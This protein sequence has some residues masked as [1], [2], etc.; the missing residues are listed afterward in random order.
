MVDFAVRIIK[1][2]NCL[3]KT[4]AGRHVANQL[5][6]SG[7]SPASNY[8]EAR[9][10]ES[11]ADF[12]HKLGIVAKELNET[13]VWLKII[14]KSGLVRSLLMTSILEETIQLSKIVT[15]SVM[16]AKKRMKQHSI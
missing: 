13:G 5:L 10:A 1:L 11:S 4:P 16:T 15:S 12:L 6:R 7:T 14:S 3:P 8:S 9:A 2:S